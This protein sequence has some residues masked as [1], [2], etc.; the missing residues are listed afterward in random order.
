MKEEK[1][2][3]KVPPAGN[4]DGEALVGKYH[5]EPRIWTEK[6]LRVLD[7]GDKGT[8]WFSLID[9]VY[10]EETLEIAWERVRQNAGAC[11]VD[12]VTVQR[13]DKDSRNRLLAVK[14][15]L[16]NRT[17]RPQ[18]IKRVW[19]DKAGSKTEKRPLGIPTVRD[20]V[21]Q[22]ALKMVIE[23]IFEHDFAPESFGFRPG[24]G[25]K[26]ALRRVEA[27]L[28][29]GHCHVVDADI[30]SFF[31][32]LDHEL[33]LSKLKERITDSR[34][35]ELI[36]QM[37]KAGILENQ[38]LIEP[39]EGTPQG[40]VISPLLANIYLNG[41]DWELA[42]AGFET[43]RYADD[44]VVLCRSAKEAEQALACIQKWMR[45][46]KLTLH[47]EKTRVVDVSEPGAYFE[48]LGYRFVRSRRSGE[49]VHVPR[50]KSMKK[51]RKKIKPLT[52]RANGHAME[53]IIGKL[54]PILRGW[55]GHFKH[56]PKWQLK[57]VDG[58]VRG[59]LRGIKRKRRKSKGRGRGRDHLRWPNHY[60]ERLGL[61]S[62]AEAHSR[63]HLSLRKG[64]KC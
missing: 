5:A 23:P 37:L 39:W 11:G 19:I 6:M 56:S 50:D 3:S 15:H 40:G 35:L 4:P 52:K 16:R 57:Q 32:G 26:D 9:K 55:Y 14:E 21:V 18:A 42:E 36:E 8:K 30:K 2:P 47:S 27:L 45:A 64:V 13:F 20:R 38:E 61:Y 58:W 51:L 29:E 22:S 63:E 7:R 12:G 33:L 53:R 46:A 31:D 28:K 24:R 62:L 54:N 34:V 41:L 1:T 25:C 44:F 60:F 17:Y 59:R 48:F 10:R 43:T 49:M